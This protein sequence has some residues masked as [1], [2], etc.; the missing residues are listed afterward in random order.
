MIS[1]SDLDNLESIIEGLKKKYDLFFQGLLRAEPVKERNELEMTIRR[2][3]Q[4]NIP[5]TSDQFRFNTIQ[6][7]FHTYMNM[8]NR[9]VT[10]IEE[11]RIERDSG[12]R[13][14]FHSH[15]PVDEENMN[16][17]FLDFLNAKKDLA[18]PCEG[19]EFSAFR[20]KLFDR[21]LDIAEKQGCKKV[22][23]KVVVE[24]GKAKIRALK[25]Q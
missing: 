10:G 19:I 25:K 4:R 21:A 17:T 2:M 18:E 12:G 14:A 11:G 20:K 3:G 9:I 8:W 6:A 13:V 22:E 23:F 15:G 24:D 5:N 7:R 16:A 1:K